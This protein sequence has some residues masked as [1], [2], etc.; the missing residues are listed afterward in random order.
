MRSI[1]SSRAVTM[2]TGRRGVA[3]R[4]A[5]IESVGVGKL[6]VEDRETEV[7]LLEREEGITATCDPGHIEAL[8]FEVGADER[9]DVLLVLDEQDRSA[10]RRCEGH[11]LARFSTLTDFAG[12][13]SRYFTTTRAPGRACPR[14]PGAPRNLKTVPRSSG[15]ATGPASVSTEIDVLVSD[16]TMPRLVTIGGL[17][18]ARINTAA[19]RRCASPSQRTPVGCL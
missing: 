4:A 7:V 5:E 17:P 15:I 1:S 8:S 14:K 19:G 9:R 12:P 18:K 11:A 6:E 10:P 3:N 16:E 13:P 2:T